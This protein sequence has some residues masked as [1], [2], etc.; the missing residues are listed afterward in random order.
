MPLSRDALL[1]YWLQLS[2]YFLEFYATLRVN[3]KRADYIAHV[4]HHFVTI[5]LLVGS[6]SMRFFYIGVFVL[7]LHDV[8][9]VLLEATKLNVYFRERGGKTHRLNKILADIG[10]LAFTFSWALCR[11]YWYPVK[12]LYACGWCA[13]FHHGCVDPNIFWPFNGL[14]W[15]LLVLHIYWFGVSECVAM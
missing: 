7:F 2:H 5:A 15:I 1:I 4:V 14:L 13:V 10:F 11:L 9:D 6:F 3:T 12:V 8:S